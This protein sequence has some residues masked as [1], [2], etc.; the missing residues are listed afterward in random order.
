MQKAELD[1]HRPHPSKPNVKSRLVAHH[2]IPNG[3]MI[4]R[5]KLM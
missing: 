2:D 1:R 3:G 5:G 4:I